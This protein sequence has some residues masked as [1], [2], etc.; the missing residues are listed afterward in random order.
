MTWQSLR[1][2]NVKDDNEAW[3]TKT[4]KQTFWN[5]LIG[6]RLC[7]PSN[8]YIYVFLML[9]TFQFFVTNAFLNY[10][11]I[12]YGFEVY[13]HYRWGKMSL[14]QRKITVKIFFIADCLQRRDNYLT[15]STLCVKFSPK[16]VIFVNDLKGSHWSMLV[17]LC[18]S[19][20]VPVPEI[21]QRRW[22]GD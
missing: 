8:W 9:R 20:R 2:E 13:Q 3:V 18:F 7:F 17:C 6:K 15:Q 1:M 16:V 10:Q 19:C 22:P 21:W 11:F 14:K 5:L 4:R 12:S